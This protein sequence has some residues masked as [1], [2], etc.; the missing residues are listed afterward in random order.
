MTYYPETGRKAPA[1]AATTLL[2]NVRP[3]GE[4]DPVDVVIENGQI[5]A[6]GVDA[7]A[8]M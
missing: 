6:I 7:G 1:S 8:N 5:A 2:T 3:Y 4:G